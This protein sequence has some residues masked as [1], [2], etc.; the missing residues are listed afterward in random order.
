MKVKLVI[1]F[2]V[3]LS[4]LSLSLNAQ[5]DSTFIRY[6]LPTSQTNNYWSLYGDCFD[7]TV[8]NV[9]EMYNGNLVMQATVSF[10]AYPPDYNVTEQSPMLVYA[11]N[12][13]YQNLIPGPHVEQGPMPDGKFKKIIKDGN[14]GYLAL[15]RY[16]LLARLDNNLQFIEYK[17]FG[18]SPDNNISIRDILPTADGYIIIGFLPATGGN[19]YA[20]C[21]KLDYDLN[22][23]WYY[24]NL[25]NSY[26]YYNLIQTSDG[27][28]LFSWRLSPSHYYFKVNAAG[29]SLWCATS[30]AGI[31]DRIVESNNK[32]YGLKYSYADN[33]SGKLS[34]YRFGEN[35]AIA[36]PDSAFM[37][38][39]T[40]YITSY[41]PLFSTLRT[42]DGSIVL[43]VP[44]PNGEI[45][46]FDS[47]FNPI[48]ISDNLT[49]ERI[50]AGKTPIIELNNSDLVYCAH[51][52]I[53]PPGYNTDTFALVRIDSNG[54]LTSIEDEYQNT[55][56]VSQM[57]AYPNPFSRELIFDIRKDTAK[58][59]KIEIYNIKGQLV[60]SIDASAKTTA[61]KPVNVASGIYIAHLVQ[62]NRVV[63]SHK[64]T[65]IST[66]K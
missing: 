50:G 21:A 2:V 44:T 34:V 12:G 41:E 54:Q 5:V 62:D 23:V 35:F 52:P 46:K 8:E 30:Q 16:A 38:I 29:D 7:P 14:G 55:P 20:V 22:V 25:S 64:V 11:R 3:L 17:V 56:S 37:N 49:E 45:Y 47:D 24:A 33:N 1:F 42:A 13:D 26:E 19:D 9:F 36:N 10:S 57:T 53:H 6:Y 43:F 40:Y 66:W 58:K 63:E 61:W 60:E 48:W 65:Y 27:G 32:Y 59:T 39:T 31:A 28:Y 15:C 51:I 4:C 18:I